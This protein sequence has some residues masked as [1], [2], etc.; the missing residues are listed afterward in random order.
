M[1]ASSERLRDRALLWGILLV[2]ISLSGEKLLVGDGFPQRI[3]STRR[4]KAISRRGP[5][6]PSRTP[7]PPGRSNGDG[8]C[9]EL[10]IETLTASNSPD[11][12]SLVPPLSASGLRDP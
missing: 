7:S 10:R 6:S 9:G 8:L 3:L 2:F 5:K 11:L 4:R 1:A 12:P